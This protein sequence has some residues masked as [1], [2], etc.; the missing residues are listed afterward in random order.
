VRLYHGSILE[1]SFLQSLDN[2]TLNQMLLNDFINIGLIVVLIPNTLR[3]NHHHWALSASVQTTGIINTDFFQ[4]QVLDPLFSMVTQTLGIM[5]HAI[6]F[7]LGIVT[8]MRAKK[9]VI[10]VKVSHA[11][12]LPVDVQSQQKPTL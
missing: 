11:S 4:L 3:V 12:S 10:F 6:R 5:L 7:T 2:L 8:L 1:A 9:Y